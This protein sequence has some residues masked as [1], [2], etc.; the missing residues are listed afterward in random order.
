[1]NSSKMTAWATLALALFGFVGGLF[2]FG[3]WLKNIRDADMAH[4][5]KRIDEKVGYITETIM[6]IE[7]AGKVRDEKID[8]I[9]KCMHRIEKEMK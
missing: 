4:I 8:G 6:R 9:I 2:A 7:E 5:E 1:M 3:G